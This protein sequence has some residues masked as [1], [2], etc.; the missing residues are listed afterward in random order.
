MRPKVVLDTN[1]LVSSIFGGLPARV[2]E[3]W[4]EGRLTLLITDEIRSEYLNTLAE[5]S[6]PR[7]LGGWK[8]A[9]RRRAVTVRPATLPRTAS[10]PED[11]V[12]LACAYAGHAR[13]IVTGDRPL[14]RLTRIGVTRIV[15][16]RTFLEEID[17]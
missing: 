6:P 5:F 2:V 15:T 1:L 9:L 3:V 10:H 11:D 16:P 8:A 13:Y 12:F 14:L 17:S 7:T 4:H